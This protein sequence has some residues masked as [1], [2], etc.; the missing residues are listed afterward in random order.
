MTALG[1]AHIELYV[2]DMES[3]AEY[4]V[5]SFGFTPEAMSVPDEGNPNDSVLLSQGSIRLIVTSGP[6][7]SE[8]LSSHG[9][10]VADIALTCDD[11]AA[12][13]DAAGASVIRGFGDVSH[14]LLPAAPG[15]ARPWPAGRRW[16]VHP[17]AGHPAAA[18]RPGHAARPRGD[19]PA[20]R[21][22]RELR[23]LL[24]RHPGAGQ[25]LQ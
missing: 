11:V 9:D 15:A 8:F 6:G 1:I 7:T 23:G 20:G 24:P 2:N 21:D 5:S 25:V 10:G 17:A 3:A 12:T 16:A 13:G 14:T 18:T 22:A 4:L 19:L